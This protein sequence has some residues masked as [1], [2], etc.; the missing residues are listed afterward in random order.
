LAS[1]TTGTALGVDG[2]SVGLRV[3]QA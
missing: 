3:P 1:S 2:G